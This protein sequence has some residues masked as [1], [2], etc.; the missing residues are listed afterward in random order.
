MKHA[1]NLLP[2]DEKSTQLQFGYHVAISWNLVPDDIKSVFSSPPREFETFIKHYQNWWYFA[3]PETGYYLM[4]TTNNLGEQRYI[5]LILDFKTRQSILESKTQLDPM[6]K[7]ALWGL[8]AILTYSLL[9]YCLFIMLS[10]PISQLYKWASELSLEQQS[11]ALPDFQYEELNAL[12][13]ILYTN[14][15]S[16]NKALD[17][18]KE[19]LSYA[20]HE[21]RTPIATLKSDITLLDKI[22]PSPTEKER[23]I[24][25][26]MFRSNHTI[27]GI[28]ETLLWMNREHQEPMPLVA[29]DVETLLKQTISELAHLLKDKNIIVT[30]ET[31]ESQQR[32]PEAPFIILITNIIRNAF[33]H[34]T[35]G[36]IHIE[37]NAEQIQITNNL[38]KDK[39][40]TN[41]GFG[42]GLKLIRKIADRFNWTVIES[43]SETTKRITFK[44]PK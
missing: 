22:S 14:M 39:N 19:F 18:E 34:T 43:Q 31:T 5:S 26:R 7:I 3:P 41:I 11:N 33:Q 23:E 42:L 29:I 4:R 44:L 13:N 38:T 8:G 10:K 20:S 16:M 2:V 17:R 35:S 6:V 30:L 27:K 12:A 24:R 25:D 32:L 21:L 36:Y 40:S 15:Q 37:Q 1:A 28:T 9:I